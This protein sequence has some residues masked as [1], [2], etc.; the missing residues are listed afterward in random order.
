MTEGFNTLGLNSKVVCGNYETLCKL[1]AEVFVPQ[2]WLE[3]E[4]KW[5][6]SINYWA[7]VFPRNINGFSFCTKAKLWRSQCAVTNS[8]QW[9]EKRTG[10]SNVENK[11][12][13][14]IIPT[15]TTALYPELTILHQGMYFTLFLDNPAP[16]VKEMYCVNLGSGSMTVMFFKMFWNQFLRNSNYHQ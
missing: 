2:A 7:Q 13:D 8:W 9:K 4:K 6:Y 12:K 15:L 1:V 14:K 5:K 3:T 10:P 11:R 16:I